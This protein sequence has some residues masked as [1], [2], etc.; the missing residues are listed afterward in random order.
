MQRL[1]FYDSTAKTRIHTGNN[2]RRARVKTESGGS[3]IQRVRRGKIRKIKMH[4]AHQ[5]GAV[6][7]P[8]ENKTKVF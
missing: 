1:S 3:I 8:S 4:Q 2:V 5:Q 6:T 7:P